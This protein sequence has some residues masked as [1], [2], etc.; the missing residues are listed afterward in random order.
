MKKGTKSAAYGLKVRKFP[1]GI[2][3]MA[4]TANGKIDF[5]KWSDQ[6]LLQSGPE[7]SFS[8]GLVDVDA[9]DLNGDQIPDL[10][11]ACYPQRFLI[12]NNL[13]GMN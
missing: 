11:V 8:S 9:L 4:A 2:R 3:L 13:G 7:L 5:F 6:K 12:L 10:L 1:T